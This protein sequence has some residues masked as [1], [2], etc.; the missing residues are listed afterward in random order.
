MPA[1]VE[2]TCWETM[3]EPLAVEQLQMLYLA[4]CGAD[5]PSHQYRAYMHVLL[6]TGLLVCDQVHAYSTSVAMVIQHS[7]LRYY[8]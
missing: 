8:R 1:L 5:G 4:V 7:A 3:F 2:S 6:D